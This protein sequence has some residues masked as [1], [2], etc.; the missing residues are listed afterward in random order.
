M[1]TLITHEQFEAQLA[2]LQ[3]DTN[4]A[5][6]HYIQLYAAATNEVKRWEDQAAK[7]KE[8]LGEILMEVGASK[9]ETRFGSATVTRPSL[10]ASYD[11][12][13]LDELCEDDNELANKIMPFR[14][15]TEVPG[16]LRINPRMQR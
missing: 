2:E 15:V 6:E 14:K 4:N 10:R 12:K 1:I 8:Q 13:K 5:A 7:A 9:L 16:F 11:W 3:S